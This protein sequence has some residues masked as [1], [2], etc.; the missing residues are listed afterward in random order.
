[1][2]LQNDETKNKQ[3]RFSVIWGMDCEYIEHNI[4][5]GFTNDGILDLLAV[6]NDITH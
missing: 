3:Q 4:K 1:M 2:T 5:H 6:S